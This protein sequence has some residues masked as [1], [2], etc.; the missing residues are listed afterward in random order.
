MANDPLKSIG[1]GV[2]SELGKTGKSIV[3]GI[4]KTPTDL[5]QEAISQTTNTEEPQ[6]LVQQSDE[7]QTKELVKDLY[8]PSEDGKEI[9]PEE[10]VKQK[11]EDKKKEAQLRQILHQEYVQKTFHRPKQKEEPK[12]DELER[13]KQE[14]RWELAQAEKKKPPPLAISR[15]QNIEKHRGSSG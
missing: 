3:K 6:K 15:A 11:A 4:V 12:A 8:K 1:E 9:Q 10:I 7:K 14:E 5:A 13:K 2:L